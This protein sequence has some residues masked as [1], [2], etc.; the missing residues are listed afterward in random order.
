MSNLDKRIASLGR[1][2]GTVAATT[3][4]RVTEWGP[5]RELRLTE[6]IGGRFILGRLVES[7]RK[8]TKGKAI[9]HLAGLREEKRYLEKIMHYIFK[10]YPKSPDIEQKANDIYKKGGT[11]L[12]I[13]VLAGMKED[14]LVFGTPNFDA[15]LLDLVSQTG[16]EVVVLEQTFRREWVSVT[17]G[18]PVG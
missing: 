6:S 13:E 15:E 17:S 7:I 10:K 1:R 18:Q 16:D 5:V 12:L 9:R 8:M 3:K 11:K 14:S 2:L 4:F